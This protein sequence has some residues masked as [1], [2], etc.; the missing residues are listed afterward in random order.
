MIRARSDHRPGF[1]LI[2]LLVVIAIIA[3]LIALLLPAVQSAREAARRAQCVNNLKQTRPGEHE[4]RKR[5]PMVPPGRRLP[6]S[7]LSPRPG[8]LGDRLRVQRAGECRELHANPALSRAAEHLQLGQLQSRRVR[9]GQ[10]TPHQRLRLPLHGGRAELRVHDGAQRVHLPLIAR[11]LIDQLLQH[12]LERIRQREPESDP[13]PA[14]A[15]LGPERLLPDVR[16]PRQPP[17]EPGLPARVRHG[18]RQRQRSSRQSGDLQQYDR[19]WSTRRSLT[20]GS[21]ASPTGPRTP[22]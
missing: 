6:D 4:L 19:A 12:V 3:V 1:T 20:S 7:A 21:P 22:S 17:A 8:P 5:Q 14:D 15:D 18:F 13:Q 16:L 2:E 10:C 11:T 9:P